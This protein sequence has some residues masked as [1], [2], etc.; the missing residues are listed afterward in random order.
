[1]TFNTAE[2]AA[3]L[4]RLN[5]E[6][7][8][9]LAR[10]MCVSGGQVLRDEAKVRAAIPH[11]S[12]QFRY[13]PVSRGSHNEGTLASTIYLAFNQ[14]LSD[15]TAFTYSISW[16]DK[17]AFW[18]KFREFGHMIRYAFFYDESGVYHTIK[19]KPLA[20]PVWVPAHPFLAPTFEANI[21]DAKRA[22]IERGKVELPKILR[23]D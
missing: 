1:V 10:R 12:T 19:N 13:N 9:S 22:M 15:R 6:G 5:N 17:Q 14:K 16:N 2:W 18:G 21:N 7:R 4:D 23:G 11:A 8:E 20:N 3:A